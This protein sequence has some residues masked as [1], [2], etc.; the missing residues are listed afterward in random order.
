MQVCFID[1]DGV[2][3]TEQSHFY[4]RR[5]RKRPSGISAERFCPITISNLNYLCENLPDLKLVVSSTWR[6]S[7]SLGELHTLFKEDGFTHTDLIIDI[8][9]SSVRR[10]AEPG[11]REVEIDKWL[12]ANPGVIDWVAIDDHEYEIDK[13]HLMLTNQED[14]LNIIMVYMLIKRFDP[15][16]RAPLF[17][18]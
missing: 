13:D 14:G 6:T 17:L 2:F 9:P 4:W 16:W 18:M 1:I 8:T 3:N 15:K 7:F 11:R 5:R 12:K 10:L